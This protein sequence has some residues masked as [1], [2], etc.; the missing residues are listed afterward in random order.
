MYFIPDMQEKDLIFKIAKLRNIE[1]KHDWVVLTKANILGV[2]EHQT[3]REAQISPIT[4]VLSQLRHLNHPVLALATIAFIVFGA[5][6]TQ[7][8]QN[9]L[10]G[11]TLYSVRSVVERAQFGLSSQDQSLVYMELANRRLNDLRRV[12]EENK[13]NNLSYAIREYE[14]SIAD[15][16]KSLALLVENNPE[17]TLQASLKAIQLYKEKSQ[18]EQILGTT[19]GGDSG[20]LENAAKILIESELADLETR[21]LTEEQEVTFEQAKTAF[22]DGDYQAALEQLWLVSNF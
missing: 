13:V 11:D 18:I 16:S 19:I 22:E 7:Q 10:P 12:A 8:A 4:R 5:I 3:L 20:E 21:T 1:P 15:A 9:S 2:E 17:N 14:A 6:F